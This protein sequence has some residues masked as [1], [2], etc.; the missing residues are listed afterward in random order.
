MRTKI[1]TV[2]RVVEPNV[3]DWYVYFSVRDAATGKMIPQKF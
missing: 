2:P 3:G 1:A